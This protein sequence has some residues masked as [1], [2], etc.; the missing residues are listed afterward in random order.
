MK[1]AVYA[2]T[3]P[4]NA[5]GISAAHEELARLLEADHDVRRFAFNDRRRG[6][7]AGVHRASGAGWQG[8]LLE[9]GIRVFIRRYDKGKVLYCSAIA[10]AIAGVRRLRRRLHAFDPGAIIVSDNYVPLLGLVPPPHS[11]VV[12][13]AHQNYSRFQGQPLVGGP[14]YYDCFLA[15]RLELR[16][17]RKADYAVFTSRYIEGVSRATF[18]PAPK[19]VVIPNTFVCPPG[20]AEARERARREMGLR[21]GDL[22]VYFPSGATK[23]KGGRYVPSIIQRL[24]HA[25]PGIAC[26]ISDSVGEETEWELQ[27]MGGKARIIAP[28][29]EDYAQHLRRVAASDLAV[30]PAL[31]ENYSSALLAAQFM[32][33]PCAVFDV[34]ANKEIIA[35]GESGFVVPYLDV[36]ALC[37]AAGAILSDPSLRERLS[38]GARRRASEICDVA[39]IKEAWRQV[40]AGL[41]GS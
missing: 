16:A 18:G 41:T 23:I 6:E 29:R 21:D 15:H 25:H 28:G 30:S 2:D 12:W 38:Q 24:A 1:I 35:E 22:L 34:G 8:M 26:Y 11:K 13:M 33:V 17:I 4:P 36:N 20:A 39:R 37:N 40:L 10:R 7:P 14:C 5:G 32:G 9:W 27:R 3:F 19:G 31:L